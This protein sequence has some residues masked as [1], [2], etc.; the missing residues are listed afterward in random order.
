MKK[1]FS[2]KGFKTVP[3][4]IDDTVVMWDKSEYPE[5]DYITI[6]VYGEDAVLVPNKKNINLI[7]KL[8]KLGYRFIFWSRTG[9]KWARAIATRLNLLDM[10][11]GTM[12]KP[13]FYMDDKP[14]DDWMERLWRDLE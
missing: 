8:H 9:E 6:N 1:P 2:I 13:F 12:G 14:A 10:A 7:R 11:V 3:V 4:D 5:N